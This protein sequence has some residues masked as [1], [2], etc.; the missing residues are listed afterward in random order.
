MNTVHHLTRPNSPPYRVRLGAW[1]PRLVGHDCITLHRTIY[2]RHT[3]ISAHLHAHE[4]RHIQQW[5]SLGVL[6]FVVQYLTQQLLHGYAHNRF[7]VDAHQYAL[8]HEAQY[9]AVIGEA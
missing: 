2:A 6:R 9:E 8:A 7:E 4:H 5:A 3:R 1:L